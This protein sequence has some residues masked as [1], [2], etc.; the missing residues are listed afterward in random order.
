[1]SAFIVV[2]TSLRVIAVCFWFSSVTSWAASAESEHVC[3]AAKCGLQFSTSNSITTDAPL[4][5]TDVEM[6]INGTALRTVVKQ[7]FKNTGG[8]WVEGIY[9]FPL[10]NGAAVNELRMK[11]GQREI[12]GEIQERQLAEKTYQNAKQSGRK[13]SLLKAHRPNLFTTKVANIG[14]FEDFVSFNRE[15]SIREL[16]AQNYT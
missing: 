16:N 13:A 4:L 3:D 7:T 11:I 5:R 8:Q 6:D 1:M 15:G 14:P 10:P 12:I 9:S 2:K